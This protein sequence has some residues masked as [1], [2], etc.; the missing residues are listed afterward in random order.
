MKP[1]K[2]EYIEVAVCTVIGVDEGRS[3]RVTS[4]PLNLEGCLPSGCGGICATL[5]G[6]ADSYSSCDFLEGGVPARPNTVVC[7]NVD[8]RATS[9]RKEKN[10]P[11]TAGQAAAFEKQVEE[12]LDVFLKEKG[13]TT[14]SHDLIDTSVGGRAL[15]IFL[16]RDYYSWKM[17]ENVPDIDPSKCD[18]EVHQHEGL[19]DEITWNMNLTDGRNAGTISSGGGIDPCGH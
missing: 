11:V 5:A 16:W 8:V 18:Y 10:P 13:T 19:R 15:A 9:T 1:M 3:T 4:L 12:E 2:I 14:L 17:D 6:S 7:S